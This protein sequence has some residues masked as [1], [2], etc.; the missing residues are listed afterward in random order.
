MRYLSR[1]DLA[2]V[3]KPVLREYWKLPEAQE[4]PWFVDPVLLAKEVLGLTVRYRHLSLD[5]ALLGLTSYD[6]AE[7]FLPDS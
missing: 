4:H 6:E 2:Q 1:S 3:A 5:G 7:V